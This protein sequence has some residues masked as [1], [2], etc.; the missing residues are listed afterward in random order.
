MKIIIENMTCSTEIA[1]KMGEV[2][3]NEV[4]IECF[5]N[6]ILDKVSSMVVLCSLNF[7]YATNTID[8][9]AVSS[10]VSSKIYFARNICQKA[11]EHGIST[12]CLIV[13][14]EIRNTVNEMIAKIIK[15]VFEHEKDIFSITVIETNVEL[16]ANSNYARMRF[17]YTERFT[18]LDIDKIATICSLIESSNN[19]IGVVYNTFV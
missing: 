10:A 7:N 13:N 14:Y 19:H 12:V 8:E 18:K 5:E 15:D 1:K 3:K 4:S 11:K 16:M 9:I 6:V 2:L 17:G